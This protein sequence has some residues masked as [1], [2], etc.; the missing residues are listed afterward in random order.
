M[1]LEFSDV[2]LICIGL[3]IIMLC[4]AVFIKY[5]IS[6]NLRL[7][8]EIEIV[9]NDKIIS[10]RIKS[11]FTPENNINCSIWQKNQQQKTTHRLIYRQQK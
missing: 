11:K 8:R 2:V 7:E 4:F 1:I 6:E 9:R 3:L 5:V 10:Y